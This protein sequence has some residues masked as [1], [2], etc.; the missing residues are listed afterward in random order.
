[1]T[2]ELCNCSTPLFISLSASPENDKT[3]RISISSKAG[4]NNFEISLRTS[5]LVCLFQISFTFTFFIFCSL[6][7]FF[8]PW[9]GFLQEL[10][11]TEGLPCS[12][13]S[14]REFESLSFCEPLSL[15][16]SFSLSES[17]SLLPSFSLFSL[18]FMFPP[19]FLSLLFLCFCFSSKWTK[20][21][22]KK[23]WCRYSLLL[24]WK[25]N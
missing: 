13:L 7:L 17:L 5:T 6:S 10:T 25:I 2:G 22:K 1:M 21:K 24:W 4:K 16:L 20:K 19:F 14:M 8:S 15:S 23:R 3:Q 9:S 11:F 12:W 18:S